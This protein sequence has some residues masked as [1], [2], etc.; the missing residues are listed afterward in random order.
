MR[1]YALLALLAVF[2]RSAVMAQE[3]PPVMGLAQAT[4]LVEASIQKAIRLLEENPC[5]QGKGKYTSDDR[6]QADES[7]RFLAVCRAEQAVPILYRRLDA[8]CV[9]FIDELADE[10]SYPC[11][12]A[13]QQIGKPA[14]RYGI[15]E[16]EKENTVLRLLLILHIVRGVEG[17][18]AGQLLLREAIDKAPQ[19]AALLNLQQAL[20]EFEKTCMWETNE[21]RKKP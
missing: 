9:E 1:V 3:Q 18:K 13:L 12:G 15:K 20:A 10:I 14:S 7:I 6:K 4:A 2:G 8:F 17:E 11:C 19:G 5:F 21:A 16:L